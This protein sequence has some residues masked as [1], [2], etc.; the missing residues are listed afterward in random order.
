[1][2]S[3]DAKVLKEEESTVNNDSVAATPSKPKKERKPF[4]WTEKR[5]EAFEKMRA[6]LELKNEI[7]LKLKHEKQKSEKDE[8]KKRVR[9]IMNGQL[10]KAK[11]EVSDE[12]DSSESSVEVTKKSKK[13]EK[14]VVKEPEKKE[15]KTRKVEKQVSSSEEEKSDESESEEE[16]QERFVR[17]KKSADKDAKTRLNTGKTQRTSTHYNQMD[18]F[19]LL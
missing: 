6:G 15:K 4:A 13:K 17:T 1:M 8:I 18:R 3:E 5:K 9:E 7:A 19:I 10:K 11:K 14:A 12:S 16:V 2:S